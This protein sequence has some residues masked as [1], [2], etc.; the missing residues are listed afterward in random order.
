MYRRANLSRTFVLVVALL[1]TAISTGGFARAF[2]AADLRN[3]RHRIDEFHSRQ[4]GAEQDRPG[5]TGTGAID[6]HRTNVALIGKMA[7]LLVGRLC[8]VEWI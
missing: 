1:L 8:R 2:P 6:L 3:D 4:F 7:S 5:Q